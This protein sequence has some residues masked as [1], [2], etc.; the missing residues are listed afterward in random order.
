MKITLVILLVTLGAC[1][2]GEIEPKFSIQDFARACKY[3][4]IALQAF[5]EIFSRKQDGSD[6]CADVATPEAFCNDEACYSVVCEFYRGNATAIECI[7]DDCMTRGVMSV[8]VTCG[9]SGGVTTMSSASRGL[10]AM[11]SF[12]GVSLLL[13]AYFVY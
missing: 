3:I 10:V 12:L 5:G 11:S 8:P 2:A 7:V 6:E 13:T 1:T 4:G 9:G